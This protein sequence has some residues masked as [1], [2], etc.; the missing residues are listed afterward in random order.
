MLLKYSLDT[1]ESWLTLEH[2]HNN[3]SDVLTD[4]FASVQS[5]LRHGRNTKVIRK[6]SNGFEFMEDNLLFLRYCEK[7]RQVTWQNI[8]LS[9]T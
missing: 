1:T 9:M 7:R 8:K 2:S 3:E 6:C 4:S 5:N